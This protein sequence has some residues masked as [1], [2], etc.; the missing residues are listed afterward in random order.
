MQKLTFINKNNESIE[1][2]TSPNSS[3][4][5]NSITG[6]ESISMTGTKLEKR[7]ITIE[8]SI[9]VK[10]N[11]SIFDAR[12]NISNILN[13]LLGEG[14]L[15]YEF[16]G[17]IVEIV[18]KVD[19]PPMFPSGTENR[20]MKYQKAMIFFL[21]DNPLWKEVYYDTR[22]FSVPFTPLFEFPFSTTKEGIEL[23]K[24]SKNYSLYNFGDVST[25]LI[26]EFDGGIEKASLINKSNGEFIHIVK[27]IPSDSK[28][29]INTENGKKEVSL[30]KENG[31]KET[32]FSY[33]TVDSSYMRLETGWNEFEFD[34]TKKGGSATVN[35]KWKNCYLGI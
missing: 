15:Y 24:V 26:L 27:P 8:F 9:V 31:D 13:P 1:I 34:V 10:E 16:D 7:M 21:C 22:Q 32:A 33:I 3:N 14:T 12:R 6:T 29:Y 18:A 5:L 2:S 23:G 28:L 25:P 11:E 4:L 20:L 17:K 35:I 30:L 19:T